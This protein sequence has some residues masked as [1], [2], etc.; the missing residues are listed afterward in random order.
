MMFVRAF[1]VRVCLL[2]DFFVTWFLLEDFCYRTYVIGFVL[3][4]YRW[5]ICLRLAHFD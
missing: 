1:V 4:D 3:N 5:M 2:D